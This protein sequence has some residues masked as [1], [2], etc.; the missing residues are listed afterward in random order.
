MADAM[1]QR[2]G[3]SEA[4]LHRL[5]RLEN[6]ARVARAD[7][8]AELIALIDDVE[9]LQRKLRS[10]CI[11]LDEELKRGA[12]RVAAIMAYR[13]GARLVRAIAQRGK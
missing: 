2:H 13:R 1:N 3:D 4:L 10:E 8:R 9:A 5:R 6:R 11:R 12:A 7:D